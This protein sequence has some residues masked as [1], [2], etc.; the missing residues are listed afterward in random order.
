MW[1]SQGGCCAICLASMAKPSM[2]EGRYAKV[3]ANTAVVDHCHVSGKVRS[4]LCAPCNRRIGFIEKSVTLKQDFAYLE[5]HGFPGAESFLI[6]SS[7]STS[8]L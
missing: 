3:Q 1:G 6:R 4:L 7:Q 8:A 5:N 2:I